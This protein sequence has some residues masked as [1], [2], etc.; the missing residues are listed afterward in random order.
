M[1]LLARLQLV[2]FLFISTIGF[3]QIN[4]SQKLPID[5]AVKIGK[6]PN[7]LTYYIRKNN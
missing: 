3:T 7:G 2:L 5:P 4:L 1:I 6:L